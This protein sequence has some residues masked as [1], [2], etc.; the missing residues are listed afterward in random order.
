MVR[1]GKYKVKVSVNDKSA[2]GDLVLIPD[3][4]SSFTKQQRDENYNT[5]MR[6]F[7]MHE[8]LATLMDSLLNEQKLI[9]NDT[10]TSNVIKEYYDSLEAIRATL[11]PVKTGRTVLFA[12]EERLRDKITD[13]YFGVNFYEGEPTASQA[14]GLNQLQRDLNENKERL[15]EK[16]KTYR[17]K[18][19]AE[20]K[21]LKKNSPY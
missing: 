17:P 8:E 4:K 13:I 10:A 16:K 3:P 7:K 12:D 11:V 15:Q 1:E 21:R 19:S 6:S 14:N 18:V 9:V 5:V 2:S 20:L